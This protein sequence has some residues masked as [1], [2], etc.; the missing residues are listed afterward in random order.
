M[1][2]ERKL[3]THVERQ[4]KRKKVIYLDILYG[5]K[6]RPRKSMR[7]ETGKNQKSVKICKLF[8]C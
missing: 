4:R 3:L 8:F 5:K 2:P 1:Q 7:T 6:T